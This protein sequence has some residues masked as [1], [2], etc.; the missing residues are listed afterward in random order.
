MTFLCAVVSVVME[1]SQLLPVLC[2]LGPTASGKT[3][4]A[5]DLCEKHPC[6]I[7]SVD[8][9]QVY[10]QM[11]IGTAKP[12]TETLKKAPHALLDI[13]DPWEHYSVARFLRDADA[14]IK[15]IHTAGRIPLLTGGTMLYYRGLWD[16]LSNLPESDPAVRQKIMEFAQ[17]HGQQELYE[18]LRRIDPESALRINSNDPQRIIRALEVLSLIHI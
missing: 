17:E 6:E 10:R 15:R 8:S 14:E 4:L 5:I 13:V 18:K 7:V 12:D 1:D 3:D 11:D 2:L 16:G 9:A